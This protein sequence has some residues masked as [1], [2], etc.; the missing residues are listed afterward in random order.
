MII[1]FNQIPFDVS[2]EHF[3]IPSGNR[4]F[5]DHFIDISGMSQP[6]IEGQLNGLDQSFVLYFKLSEVTQ[7]EKIRIRGL[8]CTFLDMKPNFRVLTNWEVEIDVASNL[9]KEFFIL[10]RCD[11]SYNT[12]RLAFGENQPENPAPYS[13]NEWLRCRAAFEY[14]AVIRTSAPI[15]DQTLELPRFVSGLRYGKEQLGNP[16]RGS[17]G[18]PYGRNIKQLRTLGVNFTRIKIY[19]MEEYIERVGLATPHFVVP[20]PE[21]IFNVPP[22]WCT[23]KRIPEF[24]KRAKSE[25]Y[26]NT[27]LEWRESY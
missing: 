21:N 25:W 6:Y 12:W 8:N 1:Q 20:Y 16:L 5:K 23:L 18:Q 22:L 17:I 14:I 19:L 13:I 4:F 11:A 24:A 3:G 27:E 15:D 9:D 10:F 7:A 2:F 26:W